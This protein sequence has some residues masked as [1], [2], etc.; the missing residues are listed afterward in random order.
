M[1][2]F[3]DL[4]DILRAPETGYGSAAFEL[5]CR[6]EEELSWI[7]GSGPRALW[8]RFWRG[9]LPQLCFCLRLPAATVT[10]TGSS[11][12]PMI[13]EHLAIRERG[14]PRYRHA[15]G[16]LP[17]PDEFSDYLRG[18]SR[19]AVRT[20][21]GH[22][23]RAGLTVESCAVERWTPGAVDSRAPHL[24]PGPV[25]SW[26]VLNADG[27]V[28]GNSIVSIDERVALLHGLVAHEPYARWLLHTAVV[29]RLCGRCDVLLVNSDDAYRMPEGARHLQRLLGYRIVRLRRPRS[30]RRRAIPVWP[31][32]RMARGQKAERPAGV[33]GLDGSAV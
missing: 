5:A 7:E 31:R 19:Q 26:V 6:A 9:S 29:E 21:V 32:V 11:G 24:T 18:R 8:L 27:A 2:Q 16:V 4:L 25:E 13:G 15:Q 1:S 10:L 22:A 12:G 20:N 23:R 28:V 17:L 30:H 14:R 33:V 3:D